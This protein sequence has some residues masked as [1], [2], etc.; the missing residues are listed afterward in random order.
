MEGLDKEWSPPSSESKA[1]YR[2]LPPGTH[3]LQVKAIGAAQVWSDPFEYAF[4]IRP[5]WW[6][7]WWAKVLYGLLIVLGL[8]G[9]YQF[10]LNR[11]LA[12]AEA[13]RLKELDEVK[14][15][16]YT[17]ITHEFR[18]PLTVILGMVDKLTANP[19]EWLSKGSEM[20]KR[21]GQNLL[22][23][24]NQMLDLSKLESGKFQLNMVQG[25]VIHYLRYVVESF[26]SFAETKD[27]RLHF[28]TDHDQLIMDYDPDNLLNILSNLL[29][30][31]I[32]F[33]D[34]GGEVYIWVRGE[35]VKSDG[36]STSYG[37]LTP[38]SSPFTSYPR[39]R[40]RH[41][42]SRREAALYLRPLLSG[43]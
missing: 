41:R 18:T 13:H 14:T 12:L 2:N 9:L 7:T 34:R 33:T 36:T 32:K 16:L 1:D 25:D 35:R 31:A 40:H 30:N 26:H 38:H 5:P 6:L 19:T 20:I 22:R 43:R 24:V 28:Q 27:I 21:N 10:L 39:S 15:R 23:L 17:N 42:H 4:T 8:Y 11:Q 3:I 37:L 29:S